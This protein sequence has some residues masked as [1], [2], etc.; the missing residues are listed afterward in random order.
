MGIPSKIESNSTDSIEFKESN[1]ASEKFA[2]WNALNRNRRN[3]A[4][5][6][7]V[8]PIPQCEINASLVLAI[9]TKRSSLGSGLV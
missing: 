2:R 5:T 6:S 8:I 7:I 1:Q 4:A 9:V 3:I